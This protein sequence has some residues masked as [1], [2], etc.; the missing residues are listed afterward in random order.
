MKISRGG[1][2]PLTNSFEY[3][4]I[5]IQKGKEMKLMKSIY[6]YRNRECGNLLTFEEMLAEWKELYDGG[7]PTNPLGWMEYYT[8]I[9]ALNI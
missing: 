5:K 2:N 9:G 6:Y 3:V 7:D 4:I 1:K 8:C